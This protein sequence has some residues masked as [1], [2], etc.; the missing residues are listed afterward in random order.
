M[1]CLK[2]PLADTR[3]AQVLNTL[4]I[5]LFSTCFISVGK[6][7]FSLFISFTSYHHLT[8]PLY[9]SISIILSLCCHFFVGSQ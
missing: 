2:K 9:L 6:T 8:A 7:F 1:L 4:Y 5:I 3:L